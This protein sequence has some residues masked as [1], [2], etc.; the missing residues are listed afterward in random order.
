MSDINVTIN[1]SNFS[2]KQ[3]WDQRHEYAAKE[4]RGRKLYD[5]LTEREQ[6]DIKRQITEGLKGLERRVDMV[7]RSAMD[8]DRWGVVHIDMMIMFDKDEALSLAREVS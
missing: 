2:P 1:T 5:Q 7:A 6:D 4:E 3:V 8:I